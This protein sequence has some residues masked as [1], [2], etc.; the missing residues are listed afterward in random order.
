MLG[1][2]RRGDCQRGASRGLVHTGRGFFAAGSGAS[3]DQLSDARNEQRQAQF[4]LDFIEAENSMGFHA[5]QEAMR[6]LARSIDH[7]RKGQV[8]VSRSARGNNTL[9]SR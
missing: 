3:D 4:L 9:F 6:I 8:A 2:W 1:N 7:A 5:P